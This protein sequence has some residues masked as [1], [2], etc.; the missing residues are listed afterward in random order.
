MG[1][2]FEYGFPTADAPARQHQRS[3]QQERRPF[4][5]PRPRE[6]P[7]VIKGRRHLLQSGR[8]S[9]LTTTTASR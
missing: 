1:L 3:V 5:S 7:W 6:W 9:W 8:R 2:W 4:H